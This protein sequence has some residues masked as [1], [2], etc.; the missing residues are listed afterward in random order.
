LRAGMPK[1]VAAT[2][3]EVNEAKSELMQAITAVRNEVKRVEGLVPVAEKK[4]HGE[5]E[6]VRQALEVTAKA[7]EDATK[8]AAEEAKRN[9]DRATDEVR[10]E[11]VPLFRPVEERIT[12]VGDELGQRISETDNVIRQAL[13]QELQMLCEKIDAELSQVRESVAPLVEQRF[14]EASAAID[15]QRQQVDA[16]IDALRED[17][18]ARDE[19]VRQAAAE[20]LAKA[21]EA[22]E[23]RAKEIDQRA[24]KVDKA[25]RDE[26]Y[27]IDQ[28]IEANLK[29][30]AAAR[31]VVADEAAAQVAKL[32][33]TFNETVVSLR[34]ADKELGLSI[35]DIENVPT[36]K[37]TWQ[38]NMADVKIKPP[39]PP[40]PG[41]EPVPYKS[42]FS[43]RFDAA[44]ARGLQ[45][46]LRMHPPATAKDIAA[47]IAKKEADSGEKGDLAVLLW[48]PKGTA[49]AYRLS[50]GDRSE[51]FERKFRKDNAPFGTVR[52]C[53]LADVVGKSDGKLEVGL[54]V[55]ESVYELQKPVVAEP[56]APDI[57][58]ELPNG[59]VDPDYDPRP[60]ILDGRMRIHRTCNNR[61]L[62]MVRTQVNYMQTRMI[63][64]VEWRLEEASKMKNC[65]PIGAPMV[66]KEFD[67]AGIEGLQLIFYPSGYHGVTEGFCSFFVSAP[68]GATLRCTLQ[69]G[70]QERQ[71]HHTFDQAGYKGRTNFGRFED[72]IGEDDC[73]FLSLDIDEAHQDLIQ[74]M[75]H[76]PASAAGIRNLAGL[77]S[78]PTPLGSIVKLKRQLGRVPAELHAV[79]VLPSLWTAKNLHD[80]EAKAE[81][82]E[83]AGPD[84]SASAKDLKMP[85]RGRSSPARAASVKSF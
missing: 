52:F 73:I 85:P 2:V 15:E 31:K 43:P 46:E 64:R 34:A 32:E 53:F 65:F 37:V 60:C 62:D 25:L 30:A 6:S 74:R 5:V 83:K 3:D 14:L 80:R 39:G 41:V 18:P 35:T 26:I 7:Q 72:I 10:R 84:A 38:I 81:K 67:A 28:E 57:P 23:Q 27:R 20:D 77:N 54:E 17:Y 4:L 16:S 9:A 68:A 58:P 66:S 69:A 50:V 82:M 21:V 59:E 13:A 36:R 76:A 40:L 48:A 24:V 49:L 19:L 12:K 71:L 70:P 63:R 75:G 56:D 51:T 61:V 11:I 8:V 22:Q 79:K 55:Q 45:L 44:G 33:E 1:K 42:Y 47:A 29:A 78:N